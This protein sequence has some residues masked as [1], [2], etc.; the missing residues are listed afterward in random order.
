MVVVWPSS[1]DS[2]RAGVVVLL[3]AVVVVVPLMVLRLVPLL[4]PVVLLP[5][6]CAWLATNPRP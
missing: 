2:G 3:V 5:W 1:L 6:G 4:V